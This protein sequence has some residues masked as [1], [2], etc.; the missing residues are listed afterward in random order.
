MWSA[1]PLGVLPLTG[2]VLLVSLVS[3][4]LGVVGPRAVPAA[5]RP[6]RAT[7]QRPAQPRARV[8]IG[9]ASWYGRPFQGRLT[10]SGERYDMSQLTAAHRTAPLGTQAVVTNLANGYA[11]R[12]RI[13]DRG[14]H[15][16]GRLLDLSYETARQLAMV[17]AGLAWVQVVFPQAGACPHGGPAPHGASWSR[18]GRQLP[19]AA[20]RPL[21]PGRVAGERHRARR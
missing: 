12:V 20:R 8:H 16:R 19:G 4:G 2:G 10:A 6:P 7:A 9:L 21:G 11:V 15:I 17:H 5:D 3:A 1:V 13:T 14:P 18:A